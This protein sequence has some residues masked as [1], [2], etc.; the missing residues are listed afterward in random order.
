MSSPAAV[1][2]VHDVLRGFMPYNGVQR[3]YRLSY[4]RPICTNQTHVPC[5]PGKSELLFSSR[6][7]CYAKVIDE[8]VINAIIIT[9]RRQCEAVHVFRNGLFQVSAF[10]YEHLRE[11]IKHLTQSLWI[12][13]VLTDENYLDKIGKLLR[14]KD[15]N[16]FPFAWV[17]G[18]AV[19][20][21]HAYFVI[22]KQSPVLFK[23][24]QHPNSKSVHKF[25]V[26]SDD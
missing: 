25:N 19:L 18:V 23:I 20:T 24:T 11:L 9:V 26:G 22:R 10:V 17:N 4:R 15:I 21:R 7:V 14:S 2:T 5:G 3:F 16:T 13:C 6:S 12:L 1:W 8:W